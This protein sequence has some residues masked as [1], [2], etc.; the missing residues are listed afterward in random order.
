MTDVHLAPESD[1]ASA[2]RGPARHDA[3]DPQ[4]LEAAVVGEFKTVLL[5]PEAEDLPMDQSFFELGLTSLM[6]TDVKQRLE[7]LLGF[8][9]EA[10]EFFNRPTVEQLIGYLGERLA[11]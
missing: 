5:M 7:T 6:L 3:A 9:I 11:G 4:L 8:G 10:S 1:E 2:P